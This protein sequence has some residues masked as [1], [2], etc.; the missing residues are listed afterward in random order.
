MFGMIESVALSKNSDHEKNSYLLGSSDG[1]INF[2]DPRAAVDLMKKARGGVC[3]RGRKIRV[4]FAASRPLGQGLRRRI[5]GGATRLLFVRFCTD[6]KA[7]EKS[8]WE[9]FRRFGEVVTV[10][11]VGAEKEPSGLRHQAHHDRLPRRHQGQRGS[12]LAVVGM[13][14]INTAISARKALLSTSRKSTKLEKSSQSHPPI[15]Q[16]NEKISQLPPIVIHHIDFHPSPYGPPSLDS[17]PPHPP[18]PPPESRPQT[19]RTRTKRKCRTSPNVSPV[20]DSSSNSAM[21]PGRGAKRARKTTI[22]AHR[23]E[24]LEE[25]EVGEE[26][27]RTGQEEEEIPLWKRVAEAYLMSGLGKRSRCLVVFG[28]GYDVKIHDLCLVANRFGRLESVDIDPTTNR[29]V[30]LFIDIQ[31]A[32]LMMEYAR[33]AKLKLKHCPLQRIHYIDYPA[34]SEGFQRQ[35]R[36]GATRNLYIGNVAASVTQEGLQKLFEPFGMFDSVIILHHKRIAF[37]NMASIQAAVT[38]RSALNG[39]EVYGSRII[40]NFAKEKV[41]KLAVGPSAKLKT[42]H[43]V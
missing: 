11:I 8:V 1:F 19:P 17:L 40:V 37:V 13:A 32:E 16:T 22:P 26:E 7:P 36:A 30:V 24:S 10:L 35:L 6:Q 25:G 38:A 21:S 23:E 31:A 33:H 43:M 15:T 9:C 18:T 4:N 29:A 14:S 28:I 34:V 42:K 3:L 20:G 12:K 2:L 39:I 27:E 5:L 41:S